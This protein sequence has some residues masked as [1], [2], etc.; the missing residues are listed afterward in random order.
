MLAGFSRDSNDSLK[1]VNIVYRFFRDCSG[2]LRSVKMLTDFFNL[3]SVVMLTDIY[4]DFSG[5]PQI[6]TDVS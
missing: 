3:R 5:E 4:R 1:Y 2:S 6:C